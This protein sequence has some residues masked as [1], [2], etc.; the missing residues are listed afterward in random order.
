MAMIAYFPGGLVADRFQA[1]KLMTISLLATAAGGFIFAQLPQH[2]TLAVLYAYWGVTTIF[3]FWAPM[4]RATRFWGGNLSQGKAFGLLDGGRGLMAAA[5]ASLAVFILSQMMPSDLSQLTHSERSLALQ[6]VIY[7]YSLMTLLAALFIWLFIP[8]ENPAQAPDKKSATTQLPFISTVTQVI[9]Q[10]VVWCQAGIVLTA[11][12]CFKGLDYFSIYATS[13][14]KYNEVEAAAMVSSASYLRPVGA[15]IAGVL[16]DKF[17]ASRVISW[18]FGL[19]LLCYAI[20][21]LSTPDSGWSDWIFANILLTFFAAFAIRGVYFALLEETKISGH[22]TGTSVGIISLL[23]FTPDIFFAPIIGRLLDASPGV[24]GFQHCFALLAFIA[25]AGII[26]SLGFRFGF[27]F[28]SSK[29][30]FMIFQVPTNTAF[31]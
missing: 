23:G 25:I 9:K 8:S 6:S 30:G 20:F 22:L 12:C 16:A 10:P 1:R 18:S 24:A 19:L 15:L 13:V 5:T 4:I 29:A 27:R 14:L 2:N 17:G 3:A 26:L 7:F 11:Y 28:G 31:Y 21:G